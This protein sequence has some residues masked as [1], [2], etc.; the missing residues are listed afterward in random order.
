MIENRIWQNSI[1]FCNVGEATILVP[2]FRKKV[3]FRTNW[4][5]NLAVFE[6]KIVNP[7]FGTIHFKIMDLLEI[8]L[9]R[10]L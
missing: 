4:T 9:E 8:L 6:K 5:N 10:G 7:L 3:K 2:Y 1:L